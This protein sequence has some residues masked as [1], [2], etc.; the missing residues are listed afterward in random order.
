MCRGCGKVKVI[1][2][3]VTEKAEMNPPESYRTDIEVLIEYV[4]SKEI[5]V[6]GCRSGNRYLF[7]PHVVRTI[8]ANDAACLVE[9]PGFRYG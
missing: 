4:G 2:A 9:L 5:R 1:R 6:V 7:G 8:D 3:A